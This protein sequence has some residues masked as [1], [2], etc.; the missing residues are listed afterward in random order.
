MGGVRIPYVF[1]I[2][3]VIV[4]VAKIASIIDMLASNLDSVVLAYGPLGLGLLLYQVF[5]YLILVLS[6]F[7]G[8]LRENIGIVVAIVILSEIGLVLYSLS[9]EA[10]IL[11]PG[12]LLFV[13]VN[14]LIL[15]LAVAASYI[16]S[17]PSRESI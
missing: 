9:R 17:R 3:F 15:A 11:S 12:Y 8:F 2:Y 16:A 13:G 6:V 4:G 14:I 10:V 5:S 1:R 7:V